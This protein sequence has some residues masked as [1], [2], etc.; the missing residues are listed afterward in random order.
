MR[1]RGAA[2]LTPTAGGPDRRADER[3]RWRRA[4]RLLPELGYGLRLLW[5]AARGWTVANTAVLVLQGVLPLAGLLLLKR[6]VD[7]L[8]SPGEAG[9]AV[10]RSALLYAGL[11]GAVALVGALLQSLSTLIGEAQGE[12]LTDHVQELIHG[13]SVALDLTY[14][15]TPEYYDDL[16]RAQSEGAYRPTRIASG[17][18]SLARSAVSLVAVGGLVLAFDPWILVIVVAL[19][20][21]GLVLRVR[22]AE[23]L[24]RWR[25][26]RTATERL[27]MMVDRMLTQVRYAKELR[28]FGLGAHLAQRHRGLRRVLRSEKLRLARRRAVADLGIH[29]GGTVAVL[30]ALVLVVTRVARGE[31]TLG[32]LVMIFG[33]LQRGLAATQQLLVA[34]AGLYEDGLFVAQLRKFLALEPRI[35]DPPAPLPVPRLERAVVCEGLG[36]TYPHRQE[37][38]LRRVDLEL[39]AGEL[40]ALV[41]ENGSGKTTLVKLLCRLYDPESGSISWDGHDLR[42]LSLVELRR[43]IAAVFQDF[44]RF[45]ATVR[46]NIG[47]GDVERPADEA[48]VAE[49]MRAAGA[50]SAVGGLPAG[51]ETPLGKWFQGGQE[52]SLGQWQKIALARAFF[53]ESQLIILDEP[54]SG[55]DALA[56]AEL[57][58]GFRRLIAGR[59]ALIISHRFSSVRMADRIFVLA[60]GAVA[61][62][63][64]HE[65]LMRRDGLYARMFTAQARMYRTGGP[66]RTLG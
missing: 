44:A 59:T 16:H 52:L 14:F 8:A 4:L 20:L 25:R 39:R 7:T 10:L 26:E 24:Y 65:E 30:G 17:L 55:L 63:G 57:F 28:L 27:A 61:E 60:E 43:Q 31:I 32:D 62:S 64:T 35:V 6:L 12:R 42:R 5:Q 29:G 38:V 41:G 9:E 50:E 54:T 47:Y 53:R 48:A 40:T 34:I 13:R 18:V 33:A 51:L 46:D 1:H 2:L 19:S 21:P 66:Q 45:P 58:R 22:V 56:E 36:F 23:Q 49:A 11:V 3:P 15:E 37:P